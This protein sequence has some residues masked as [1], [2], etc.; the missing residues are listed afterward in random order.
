MAGQRQSVDERVDGLEKSVA[1]LR[2][3]VRALQD[4]LGGASGAEGAIEEPEAVAPAA[5]PAPSVDADTDAWTTDA[6]PTVADPRPDPEME[7]WA[8][9]EVGSGGPPVAAARV[10]EVGRVGLERRIGGQVFAIAG[11]LIV[12]IGLALAVKVVIDAGWFRLLPPGLRCAG[13]ALVGAAFL[14]AGEWLRTR[15]KAIAVA[16]CNAAGLGA[17]YVAAFASFGVFGLVSVPVAFVLMA[18]VAAIGFGIAMRHGFLSTAMLSL[19][20]AYLVP[21]LLA[22]SDASPLVLPVYVLLLS[23]ASLSLVVFRPV[24]FG[25]LRDV[26]WIGTGVLG[27]FWTVAESGDSTWIVLAFWAAAWGLHQAELLVSA[28]RGDLT[29]PADPRRGRLRRRVEPV[30]LSV[31]TTTG[32]VGIAAIVLS[33]ETLLPHWLASA[34]AFVTTSMLAMMFGGHLRVLRDRPRNGL[35][36]LGAAHAAQ[37]GALLIVT[38]ALALGGWVEVVSWLAMGVGAVVA[39][40]W[41]GARSLDVYGV[42]LLCIA[43]VRLVTFDLFAGAAGVPWQ[44]SAGVAISPWGVLMLGAGAAWLTTAFLLLRT[45]RDEESQAGDLSATL[46]RPV[47]AFVAA[48]VGAASVSMA[49]AHPDSSAAAICMAWL[50]LSLVWR[51]V[52]RVEPRL[53]FDALGAVLACGAIAPWVVASSPAGWLAD[54]TAPLTH[55]AF[56]LA[57]A[58]TATLLAHAW[59]ARRWCSW[60]ESGSPWPVLAAAAGVVAFGATSIE[61]ARSASLLAADETAQRAAVS[62]WWGLWGVSLIVGGFARRCAPVRYV[63]LSVL[64]IAALKAVVLDLAGVPPVWRV[65][66]FV[67]LGV[68]ML[69]VAVLYG[70]VSDVIGNKRTESDAQDAPAASSG[71][72]RLD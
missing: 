7:A 33:Q 68:L 18:G 46:A 52:A 2:M 57:C 32:A 50:A 48:T 43:T 6:V 51:A 24:P 64:G 53:H 23:V 1:L 29:P 11:A 47:V 17:M 25:R 41:I 49:P 69:G 34:S 14:A 9:A 65:A 8:E 63:G 70:R 16:G 21:I 26:V 3:Q 38:I 71:T 60:S 27:F 42:V 12:V 30:L 15:V 37:A 19:I 4:R 72:G 28:G 36:M 31:A 5:T 13:I 35:E 62:I 56:W 54:T 67:G 59:A 22:R 55:P 44:V 66:S 10:R 39:G 58:V 61:V 45:V 20:G 40:R